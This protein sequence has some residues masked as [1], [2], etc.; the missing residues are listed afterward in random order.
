MAS[1][2]GSCGNARAVGAVIPLSWLE[3]ASSELPPNSSVGNGSESTHRAWGPRS[4]DGLEGVAR[5][6]RC[7]HRS[8][9][10]TWPCAL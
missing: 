5:R 8:R 2:R 4:L 7:G 3:D 9:A 6:W 1:A 10:P